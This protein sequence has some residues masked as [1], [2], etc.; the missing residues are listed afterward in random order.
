MKKVLM[1]L[2]AWGLLAGVASAQVPAKKV[3]FS[4]SAGFRF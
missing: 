2:L 3:A 4:V 1:S